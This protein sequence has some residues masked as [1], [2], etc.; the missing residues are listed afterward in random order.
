MGLS[1]GT[2]RAVRCRFEIPRET[3]GGLPLVDLVTRCVSFEVALF[4]MCRSKGPAIDLARPNGLGKRTGLC[5]LKRIEMSNLNVFDCGI[6]EKETS[7]QDLTGIWR[8]GYLRLLKTG[9]RDQD[10]VINDGD[11]WRRS[12]GGVSL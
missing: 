11:T 10:S 1:S 5:P 3:P 6:L 7:L 9:F 12:V 2:A 4:K 8:Y